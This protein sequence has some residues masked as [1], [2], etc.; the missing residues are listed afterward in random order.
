MCKEMFGNKEIKKDI[1]L[2]DHQ[3]CSL[4]CQEGQSHQYRAPM[5]Q[6]EHNNFQSHSIL[7][8]VTELRT[9]SSLLMKT[10]EN[11]Y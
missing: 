2:A 9:E 6:G 4:L 10:H 3:F 8:W 1:A 5:E 11:L 7:A